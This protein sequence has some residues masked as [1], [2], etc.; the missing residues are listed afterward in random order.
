MISQE[1]SA[2]PVD[3]LR[4]NNAAFHSKEPQCM[5][6]VRHFSSFYTR[7][8]L[9]LLE[10]RQPLGRHGFWEKA[11]RIT[12]TSPSCCKH[13]L[14]ATQQAYHSYV[15]IISLNVSERFIRLHGQNWYLNLNGQE[16]EVKQLSIYCH[17]KKACNAAECPNV[18]YLICKSYSGGEWAHT[19]KQHCCTA[20]AALLPF[21]GCLFSLLGYD[22]R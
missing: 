20:H 1:L 22:W 3:H 5:S 9:L 10:K 7:C 17:T 6:G 19:W 8:W 15:V 21:V 2:L 4:S 12:F 14:A 16:N 18:I 11:C 13:L